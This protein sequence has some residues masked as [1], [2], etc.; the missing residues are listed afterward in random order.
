[1]HSIK[2]T[3]LTILSVQLSGVNYIC[4]KCKLSQAP[5][6]H[7]ATLHLYEFD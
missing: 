1:M 3:I 2:I 7:Y 6:N 5:G 4:S